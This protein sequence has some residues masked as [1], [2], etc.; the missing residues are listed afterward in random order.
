M[1]CIVSIALIEHHGL[2]LLSKRGGGS[3]NCSDLYR[4]RTDDRL[5]MALPFSRGRLYRLLMFSG[6]ERVGL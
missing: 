6:K 5:Y 3:I 4:V 2:V 1:S